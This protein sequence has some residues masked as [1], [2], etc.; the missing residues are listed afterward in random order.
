MDKFW[1]LF[2]QCRKSA[3]IT[4]KSLALEAGFDISLISK[5]EK[6]MM[7]PP[8]K[9][10]RKIINVLQARGIENDVL[11]QL[12]KLAGYYLELPESLILVGTEIPTSVRRPLRV[13]LCHSSGDKPTVRSLY[14]RLLS[15]SISVWFDEENLLPGQDWRQVIPKA[16]RSSDV[17]IVCLSKRAV[18]RAGYLQK[19]IRYAIDVADE[20]PEDVIF[21]IPLKL[22]ECDVP[23]RLSRWQWVN[24]Y[25][26]RGFERLM[27]ALNKRAA[28]VLNN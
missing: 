9:T 17:V 20:Q 15:E 11:F 2:R 16:V 22:E 7:I 1:T 10:L 12:W 25:E 5:F 13:F 6:G 4:Q 24:Y 14:Q 27:L 28:L 23:D 19:E 3:N 18:T 26:P 21:L 8:P